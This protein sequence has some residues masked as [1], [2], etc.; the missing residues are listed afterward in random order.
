MKI[1]DMINGQNITSTEANFFILAIRHV[2]NFHPKDNCR[3]QIDTIERL[4]WKYGV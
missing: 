4:G 2:I 3:D 1:I